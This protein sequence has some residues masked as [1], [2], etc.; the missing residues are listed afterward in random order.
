MEKTFTLA[1][2]TWLQEI[3]LPELACVPFDYLDLSVNTKSLDHVTFIMTFDLHLKNSYIGCSYLNIRGRCPIFAPLAC[4]YMFLVTKPFCWNQNFRSC[5][6]DHYIWPTLKKEL[7]LII[8]TS[9]WEGGLWSLACLCLVTSSLHGC[10]TFDFVTFT[11]AYI[12]KTWLHHF[13]R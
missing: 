12:W 2:T 10:E 5:R 8:A 1:I 11:M 9:P 13:G 3:K 4:L 7:T 6:L